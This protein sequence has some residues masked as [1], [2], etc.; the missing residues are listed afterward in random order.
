[1]D[2]D[3]PSE[4]LKEAAISA[5]N[6]A[7]AADERAEGTAQSVRV[8][9]ALDQQ[10]AVVTESTDD[11]VKAA[12]TGKFT[13][14]AVGKYAEQTFEGGVLSL[15]RAKDGS[16][17]LSLTGRPVDKPDA[18]SEKIYRRAKL[19]AQRDAEGR[20]VLSSMDAEKNSVPQ[21]RFG[22][23]DKSGEIRADAFTAPFAGRVPDAVKSMLPDTIGFLQFTGLSAD[24]KVKE[25]EKATVNEQTRTASAEKRQK[26]TT[27]FGGLHAVGSDN[28][29]EAMF[30]ASWQ[31]NFRP[32]TDPTVHTI[33]QYPLELSLQFT[34][35]D[36]VIGA[37]TSGFE[38]S[39]N[40]LI[41]LNL[42]IVTGLAGGQLTTDAGPHYP[43]FGPVFGAGVGFEYHDIRVD[44]RYD[45]LVNTLRALE[46]F[47]A[48][49]DG[50]HGLS[51]KVG[52]A[53]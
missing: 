30:S 40:P 36:A 39:A 46:E 19:T 51:L 1:L 9:G 34:P 18:G 20:V 26:V 32:H 25:K 6:E 13:T 29:F 21:Y 35:S 17:A 12:L 42:R 53:F 28:A 37:I 10:E 5:S 31:I 16:F 2:T 52:P 4:T 27:G 43:A 44:L 50:A 14:P 8:L 49:P 38:L 15:V 41:P 47:D 11:A 45:Y 33:A 48:A 22:T 24:P 23:G 7:D 3:I